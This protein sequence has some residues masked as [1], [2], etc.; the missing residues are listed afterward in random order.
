ME[1]IL[2]KY[3]KDRLS[4]ADHKGK[5]EL[6]KQPVLT[7]SRDFGCPSREITHMLYESISH[8]APRGREPWRLMSKEI[9]QQAASELHLHPSK[10]N[11]V[12]R[13][14]DK[15]TMD[16][17]VEALGE[18]YYKSDKYIRKTITDVV[19]RMA[20]P[21][22]LIIIGMGACSILINQ[23]NAFHI[24]L[25]G[26]LKWRTE[27]ISRWRDVTSQTASKQVRD[28]DLQRDKLIT[29]FLPAGFRQPRYDIIFDCMNISDN[30]I[31]EI[32]HDLIMRRCH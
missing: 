21:G 18:K 14:E 25:T 13:A 6:P 22:N 15:S 3:M 31:V 29:S 20:A 23:P 4:D 30:E 19:K 11:Y 24:K 10:L 26:P 1:N 17:I 16:E 28:V 27:N 5:I 8:G 7:I 32:V 2:L 12:F 9:L